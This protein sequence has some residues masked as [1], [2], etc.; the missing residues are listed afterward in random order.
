[1]TDPQEFLDALPADMTPCGCKDCALRQTCER[2]KRRLEQEIFRAGYLEGTI[3]CAVDLLRAVRNAPGLGAMLISSEA[4]ALDD[5]IARLDA[6][7]VKA[8]GMDR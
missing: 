3:I 2:L 1:M 6:A 5:V 8:E 4:I 7:L